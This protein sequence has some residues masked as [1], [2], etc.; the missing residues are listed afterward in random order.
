MVQAV[1]CPQYGDLVLQPV[2]QVFAQILH[3]DE[4]H[5]RHQRGQ[6]GSID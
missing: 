1:H 6:T 2:E 3:Q 5:H 4:Q